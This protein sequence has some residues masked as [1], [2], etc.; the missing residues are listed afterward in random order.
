MEKQEEAIAKLQE[1]I[2][3]PSEESKLGIYYEEL[4]FVDIGYEEH[5]E[6]Q[7]TIVVPKYLADM[8]EDIG[9]SHY[10]EPKKISRLRVLGKFI[11]YE[12]CSLGQKQ[13]IEEKEEA[14]KK[15]K[16]SEKR[17]YRRNGIAKIGDLTIEATPEQLARAGLLYTDY[18]WKKTRGKTSSKEIADTSKALTSQ[19]VSKA[20]NFISRLLNRTNDKNR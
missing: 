14:L 9:F 20:G 12:K 16:M 10:L 11:P 8:A 17:K 18:K 3:N 19:K 4:V 1:K 5:I 13:A 6:G 7:S 2:S 15:V